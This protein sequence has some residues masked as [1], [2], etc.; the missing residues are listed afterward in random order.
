MLAEF[1]RA[2]GATLDEP[3]RRAVDLIV[4]Y[5]R[6]HLGDPLR[7]SPIGVERFLLHWLPAHTVLDDADLAAVPAA[8]GAWVCYARTAD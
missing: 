4:D 5:G 2:E 1:A 6:D 8:L 7:W 3:A